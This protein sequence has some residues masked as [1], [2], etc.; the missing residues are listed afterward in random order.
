MKDGG[1]FVWRDAELRHP[2]GVR[3]DRVVLVD[4]RPPAEVLMP[5]PDDDTTYDRFT[6]MERDDEHVVYEFRGAVTRDD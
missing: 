3:R 2:D 6:V 1:T 5:T 4:G